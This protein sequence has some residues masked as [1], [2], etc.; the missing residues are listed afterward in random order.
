VKWEDSL[1]NAIT[2]SR[3]EKKPILLFQLVGDMRKEGC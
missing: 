2:R 1:E 3:K